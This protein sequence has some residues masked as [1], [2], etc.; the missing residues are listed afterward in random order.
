MVHLQTSEGLFNARILATARGSI[1]TNHIYT[2]H[3]IEDSTSHIEWSMG[4]G[5]FYQS[6][7]LPVN[8][9]ATRLS[10]GEQGE[11]S[12]DGKSTTNND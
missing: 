4:I 3:L 6:W 11:E 2:Q 7:H 1:H 12:K 9:T 5:A 8:T 10:I